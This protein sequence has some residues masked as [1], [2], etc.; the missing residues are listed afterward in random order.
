MLRASAAPH[1][2]VPAVLTCVVG[3]RLCSDPATED[4]WKLRDLSAGVVATV[5]RRFGASYPNLQPRI[6][7]ALFEAL[8]DPSKP[9]ATQ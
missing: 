9:L 6:T 7:K 4:H 2:L 5:C 8:A 1:Q 3:K